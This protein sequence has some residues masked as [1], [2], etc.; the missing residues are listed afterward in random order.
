MKRIYLLLA[1][2]VANAVSV[3]MAQK[4][5]YKSEICTINCM[6]T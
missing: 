3:V 4:K 2:L 5:V 1:L 6:G